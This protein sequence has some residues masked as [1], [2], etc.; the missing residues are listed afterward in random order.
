MRYD[1]IMAATAPYFTYMFTDNGARFYYN[2]IPASADVQTY[3]CIFPK[4]ELNTFNAVDNFYLSTRP[5]DDIFLKF[6]DLVISIDIKHKNKVSHKDQQKLLD[7]VQEF[8]ITHPELF[9]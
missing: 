5:T 6:T 4:E 1:D 9:I 3:I 8:R 2:F 7:K